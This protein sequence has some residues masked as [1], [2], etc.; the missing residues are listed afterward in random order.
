M[1]PT[2]S[3]VDSWKNTHGTRAVKATIGY[4]MLPVEIPIKLFNSVNTSIS[5]SGFSTAQTKPR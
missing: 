1:L 5:V 2:P 4:G 3:D